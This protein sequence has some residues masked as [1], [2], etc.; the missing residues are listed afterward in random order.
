MTKLLL[1]LQDISTLSHSKETIMEKMLSQHHQTLFVQLPHDRDE[2]RISSI[3]WLN[4]L[5]DLVELKITQGFQLHLIAFG[6][7]CVFA[8]KTSQLLNIHSLVC[9]LPT[10][11]TSLPFQVEKHHPAVSKFHATHKTSLWKSACP[12]LIINDN[13]NK[14]SHG[15]IKNINAPHKQLVFLETLMSDDIFVQIVS[16]QILSFIQLNLFST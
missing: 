4:R 2:Q 5:Y 9:V 16:T 1:V 7:S 12:L 10:F 14:M 8:L 6:T 11:H 15:K 13:S 3:L